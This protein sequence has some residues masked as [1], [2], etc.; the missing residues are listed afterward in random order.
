MLR[1][2]RKNTTNYLSRQI[3]EKNTEYFSLGNNK[4][5]SRHVIEKNTDYFP[6]KNNKHLSIN[7]NNFQQKRYY[8]NG[9]KYV[10]IMSETTFNLSLAYFMV[11]IYS[12]PLLI[13]ALALNMAHADIM[14]DQIIIYA[15]LYYLKGALFVY[16]L[17]II[18]AL[19]LFL[20][21]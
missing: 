6:V 10:K 5:L 2:K 21:G 15:F 11:F 8:S 20:L 1:F 17:C 9:K 12:I 16:P 14:I 18:A 4:H 3:I 13:I 19:V 7:Q